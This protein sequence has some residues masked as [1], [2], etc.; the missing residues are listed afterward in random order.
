MPVPMAGI[1]G[2]NGREWCVSGVRIMDRTYSWHSSARTDPPATTA[3]CSRSPAT[4]WHLRSA[5]SRWGPIFNF[6]HDAGQH[7]RRE[8]DLCDRQRGRRHRQVHLDD[9][10]DPALASA[11]LRA[12]LHRFGSMDGLPAVVAGIGNRLRSRDQRSHC[13]R[14]CRRSPV[15]RRLDRNRAPGRGTA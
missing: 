12:G 10:G 14:A 8:A 15:G 5:A 4:G 6:G 2:I 13:C 11:P 7:A 9:G 3:P 1:Y